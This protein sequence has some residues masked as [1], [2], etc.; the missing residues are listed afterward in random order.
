MLN[1]IRQMRD[2]WASAQVTGSQLGC[3]LFWV[4]TWFAWIGI[5]GF[6]IYL[7]V[8]GVSIAISAARSGV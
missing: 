2:E 7:V 3:I 1:V 8:A 4:W 5:A 6:L